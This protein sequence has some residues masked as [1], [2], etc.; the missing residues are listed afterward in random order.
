MRFA[1][2]EGG[3]SGPQVGGEAQGEVRA[4]AALLDRLRERLEIVASLEH[5][6]RASLGRGDARAIDDTTSRL[7]TVALEVRLLAAELE[8]LPGATGGAGL[9]VARA[10][11]D[12]T[13]MRLAR[14][15]AVGGGLLERLIALTR[16]FTAALDADTE[17]YSGN[18]G[19]RERP[20]R[21]LRLEEEA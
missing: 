16:K 11:L 6:M 7:E 2:D 13:A 17:T 9:D 1:L 20:M 14:S 21:G 18:G 5:E 10:E 19:V 4:R 12:R 8:R 3:L 15:S